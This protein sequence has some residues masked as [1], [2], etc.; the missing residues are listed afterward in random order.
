MD[1]ELIVLTISLCGNIFALA[2]LIRWH[3]KWGRTEVLIENMIEKTIRYRNLVNELQS[4]GEDE[5][6]VLIDMEKNHG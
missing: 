5:A 3:R 6:S 2:L 4:I 1:L